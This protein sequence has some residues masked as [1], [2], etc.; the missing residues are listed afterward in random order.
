MS[1]FYFQID[2][3]AHSE[4]TAI[5]GGVK[6]YFYGLSKLADVAPSLDVLLFFLMHGRGESHIASQS[7][8]FRLMTKWYSA[9][10]TTP[11]VCITID[12]PNHGAR[13]VDDHANNAWN[14]GNQNHALD[15]VS[16]IDT[17]AN[18]YAM[19]VD[20]APAYISTLLSLEGVASDAFCFRNVVSGISLGGHATVRFAQRNTAKVEAI[21]PII[22]CTDLSSLLLNRLRKTYKTEFAH[23][24]NFGLWN[25]LYEELELSAEDQ[26]KYPKRFHD[27]LAEKD[28][29]VME[30]FGNTQ[31]KKLFLFGADDVLVSEK[32]SKLWLENHPEGLQSFSL[33]GV[34]HTVTE[35]MVSHIQV[36]L[37]LLG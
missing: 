30:E 17:T 10:Q 11:L 1:N 27:F 14:K 3:L 13:L 6:T 36:F 31:T 4:H 21:V 18:E 28:R 7:V 34:G 12:N 26:V 20:Y 8:A 37:S 24:T 35:E 15:M 23:L 16:I 33:S 9:G 29:Q 2:P 22:G 25:V 32:Y 19:L 5:I